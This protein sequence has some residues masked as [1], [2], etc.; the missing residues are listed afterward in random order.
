MHESHTNILNK[1]LEKEFG[2]SS[3]NIERM[4]TGLANEVYLVALSSKK[5]IVRLNTDPKQMMGSERH[6]PLLK[7]KGIKVP[8]ILASDYSK[9]FVPFAYQI[10]TKI[11]G[12]DIGAVI[13]TLSDEELKKLGAEIAHIIDAL[14]VIPT[15]GK[16]G[17]VGN[18]DTPLHNTWL[19]ILQP[20][21]IIERNEQTGVVGQIYVDKYFTVLEKFK[22]YFEQVPS[23]FYYDDMSSKNVLINNGSFAGLVDLDTM[24]YGDPLEVIGRI[25]ASWFG[26]RYGQFYTN[27]VED[28]LS[29]TSEQ[30]EIVTAY[31]FFNR[32][33]WLSERGIK[34]NANTSEEIDWKLV[35][36]DRKIIDSILAK[37]EGVNKI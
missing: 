1:I 16:F 23:T 28:A 4:T 15:N 35:E 11:E 21:K 13:E 34:F 30:R 2:E 17:W 3:E 8:D 25:E 36:A 37:I 32:V 27:S 7:S 19:E 10:Q 29:L 9:S 18:D 6:I 22:S 24:A 14:K 31:A 12:K 5:V 26:T 20:N 33:H